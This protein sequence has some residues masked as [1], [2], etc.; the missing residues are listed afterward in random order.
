MLR[1]PLPLASPG[2]RNFLTDFT[3]SQLA[4]THRQEQ[5]AI[6]YSPFAFE[7][8]TGHL[9]AVNGPL[10]SHKRPVYGG[11]TGRLR[12]VCPMRCN[13]IASRHHDGMVGHYIYAAYSLA[14]TVLQRNSIWNSSVVFMGCSIRFAPV[15][16]AQPFGMEPPF[17]LAGTVSI[18]HFLRWQLFSLVLYAA[19]LAFPCPSLHDCWSLD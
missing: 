4:G 15:P 7:S 1:G 11:Q 8:L 16:S 17:A 10:T 3:Y 5:T 14:S 12:G 18:P 2:I 6:I 19:Q 13:T 9:Q